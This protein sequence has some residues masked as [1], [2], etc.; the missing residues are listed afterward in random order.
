VS[1]FLVILRSRNAK[2]GDI[3]QIYASTETCPPSC[4]MRDA[5]Y[6]KCGRVALHWRHVDT[7][8]VSF[9]DMLE[10]LFRAPRGLVRYGVAG[11]LPGIGDAID[12][13]LLSNLAHAAK[14]A[15]VTLYAYTHKP[16]TS[17]N[18]VAIRHAMQCG[19]VINLS[20]DSPSH[21][22]ALSEHGL[23]VVT[24]VPAHVEI[25]KTPMGRRIT[26]CPAYGSDGRITCATC[27]LCAS[28]TRK[29]IIGLPVHGALA[30]RW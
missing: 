29:S 4:G 12:A 27:K 25:K 1:K 28:A 16:M 22:D 15:G 9:A 26:K 19:M 6:A 5:C 14:S 3:P 17:A 2:T 20:A 13:A 30:A 11:D 8:G 23:P 18:L 21:A 7:K 10:S 24:V